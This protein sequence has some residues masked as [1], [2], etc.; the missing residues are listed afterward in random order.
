MVYQDPYGSSLYGNPFNLQDLEGTDIGRRTIFEQARPQGLGQTTR[1]RDIFSSM[2]DRVLND[3]LG[4]V[5]TNFR[6][7]QA[8]DQTFTDYV[9]TRDFGRQIRR[10]GVG[11][12]VSDVTSAA[13]YLFDR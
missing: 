6:E 9:N 8:P 7:G 10:E 12:G 1:Q 3:F 13:R 5:G 11:R 4:E 2:F